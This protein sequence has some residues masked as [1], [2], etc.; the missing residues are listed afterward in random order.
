MAQVSVAAPPAPAAWRLEAD[1]EQL[2]QLLLNVIRN[3]AQ[4]AGAAGRVD[5][6]CAVSGDRLLC[7]VEDDGP[8]FAPEA[9]ENL[10]TPFFTTREGGTGLGL[11]IS[12]RILEDLGGRL[13]VENRDEGGARV[14]LDFPRPEGA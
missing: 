5:V 14:I 12:H 7:R 3:G 2:R 1:R 6:T 10:A 8:G 9:L 13:R 4:A 11:A